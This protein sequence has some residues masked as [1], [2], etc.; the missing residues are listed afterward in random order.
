MISAA[1][2]MDWGTPGCAGPRGLAERG[3]GGRMARSALPWQAPASEKFVAGPQPNISGLGAGAAALAGAASPRNRA[4]PAAH[5]AV[6][7]PGPSPSLGAQ[8]RAG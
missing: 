4:A 2:L 3:M 5:A 6:A 1:R 8:L 7:P